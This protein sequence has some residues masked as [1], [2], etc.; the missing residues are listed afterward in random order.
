[1]RDYGPG[2]GQ[3]DLATL[4]EPSA[5]RSGDSTHGMGLGLSICRSII[6]AHGGQIRGYN[7]EPCGAVF[8]LTLPK[9]DSDEP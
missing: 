6:R 8:T 9:E 5:R 2:L 4:F 1:M 3:E 7:G